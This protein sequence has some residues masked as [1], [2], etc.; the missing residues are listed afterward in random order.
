MAI[1][2]SASC[3]GF[4]DD[5]IHKTLPADAIAITAVRHRELLSAQE[6]GASIESREGRPAVRR[7]V[8]TIGARRARLQRQVK[9]EAARRIETI[10][11]LWRQLNDQ[12]APSPAGAA[13]FAAI[14]AIRATSD[15]IE[16]EID[17]LGA[18]ALAAFA[19]ADHPLWPAE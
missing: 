1:H 18:D 14:D 4:F 8:V 11:P 13:R 2:F 3:N 15:A 7:L 9:R 12:R 5:A 16:A 19:I 10:A 17:Q 6:Q